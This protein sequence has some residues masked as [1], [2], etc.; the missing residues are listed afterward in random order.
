MLLRSVDVGVVALLDDL[1]DGSESAV[2]SRFSFGM[3]TLDPDMVRPLSERFGYYHCWL[4]LGLTET[5]NKSI[6]IQSASKN[7][8]SC[9]RLTKLQVT[10]SSSRVLKRFTAGS[11][12]FG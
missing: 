8:E 10:N 2:P 11:Y 5:F 3:L 9:K 12:Q 1:R 6:Q 4:L 7:F